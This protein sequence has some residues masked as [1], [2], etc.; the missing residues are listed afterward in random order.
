MCLDKM[1]ALLSSVRKTGDNFNVVVKSLCPGPIVLV[2][3]WGVGMEGRGGGGGE[4]RGGGEGWGRRGGEGGVLSMDVFSIGQHDRSDPDSSQCSETPRKKLPQKEHTAPLIY[5]L[6]MAYKLTTLINLQQP[7][8]SH[9][10]LHPLD[11]M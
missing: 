11:F 7:G 6:M 2:R 9:L 10:I 3:Q 5:G 4:G 8:S 1:L